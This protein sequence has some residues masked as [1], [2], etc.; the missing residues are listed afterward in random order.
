M[1]AALIGLLP[2]AFGAINNITNAISN[3]RL[4]LITAKTDQERID[5]QERISSLQARRDALIIAEA[6]PWTIRVQTFIAF[7][8]G[9]II[10]KLLA[11]D[12]VVGS[13]AGC[14]GSAGQDPSCIIFRTDPIDPT[15]WAVVTAV[16]GFYFLANAITKLKS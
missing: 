12:K 7:S 15:Q 14:A 3:E 9:T 11:W 5:A 8:A 1:W 2:G 10:F 16:V 4:A 13:L 6:N